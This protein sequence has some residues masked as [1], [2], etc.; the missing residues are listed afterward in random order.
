M[1]KE[2]S[3][4]NYYES[5]EENFSDI[6]DEKVNEIMNEQDKG[7]IKSGPSESEKIKEKEKI[8]RDINVLESKVKELKDDLSK[9]MG[10]EG[11]KLLTKIYN[12]IESDKMQDDDHYEEIENFAKNKYSA[13][14][15]EKF[16]NLYLLLVSKD[17]QLDLKKNQLK[18]YEWY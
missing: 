11:Y 4:R 16:D 12:K 13:E 3:A 2:E 18:L 17:A 14:T 7:N 10:E 5:S 15:K 8:I 6:D 1:P 9:L